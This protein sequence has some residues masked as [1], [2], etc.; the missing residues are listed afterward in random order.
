MYNAW[1]AEK[2]MCVIDSSYERLIHNNN[3]ENQYNY[4]FTANYRL[5]IT[6]QENR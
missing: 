2:I 6:V 1:E 4:G 5:H 3:E